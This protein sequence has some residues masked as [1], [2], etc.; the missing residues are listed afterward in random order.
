MGSR[1]DMIYFPLLLIAG[2]LLSPIWAPVIYMKKIWCHAHKDTY[3]FGKQV[4]CSNC[5]TCVGSVIPYKELPR[6]E[7]NNLRISFKRKHIIK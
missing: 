7:S 1:D 6:V 3:M 2:A 5:E 4:I